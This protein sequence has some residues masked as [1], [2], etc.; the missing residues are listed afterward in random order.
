MGEMDGRKLVV[1]VRES[2]ME[3]DLAAVKDLERRCQ[4]GL[5]GD[6][7]AA[8]DDNCM[9]LIA[10]QVGDPLARVCHAPDHIMLVSAQH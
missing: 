10:E 4:V 3:R 2:N 6:T 8:D 1:R 9:S 7:V 5:S